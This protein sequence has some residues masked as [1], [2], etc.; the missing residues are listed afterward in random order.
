MPATE[1]IDDGVALVLGGPYANNL[2]PAP[3]R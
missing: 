3:D 1:A 2:S